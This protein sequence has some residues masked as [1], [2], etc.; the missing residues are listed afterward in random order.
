MGAGGGQGHV[1]G[2][3][4][5][6]GEGERGGGGGCEVESALC[7]WVCSGCTSIEVDVDVCK[8]GCGMYEGVEMLVGVCERCC[9]GGDFCGLYSRG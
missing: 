5:M 1:R 2:G 6:R 3:S 8:G 4:E 9:V 7:R